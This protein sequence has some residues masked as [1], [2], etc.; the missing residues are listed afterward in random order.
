MLTF[1]VDSLV[2]IPCY[3]NYALSIILPSSFSLF[4]LLTFDYFYLVFL[5]FSILILFSFYNFVLCFIYSYYAVELLMKNFWLSIV[6]NGVIVIFENF[7][8]Q[9]IT[10]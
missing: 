3:S 7:C 6:I 5:V 1:Y 9:M 8:G 2:L 4:L 10:R